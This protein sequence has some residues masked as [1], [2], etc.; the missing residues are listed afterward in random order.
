MIS[1]LAIFTDEDRVE[2]LRAG[3][4]AQLGDVALSPALGAQPPAGPQRGMQE[5]EEQIVIG[6]PVERG[7][8]ENRVDGL[9]QLELQQVAL[10][11]VHVGAAPLTRRGD[12]RLGHVHR[13]DPAM[14]QPLDQRLGDPARSATRVEHRLVAGEGEA[15]E[16][17]EAEGLHRAGYPV[18]ALPVPFA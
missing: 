10:A 15:V 3:P 16:Y 5:T 4:A 2:E 12:H 13:D 17:G 1:Q 18:V 9:V 11:D 6:D 7:G 8:R 14:R